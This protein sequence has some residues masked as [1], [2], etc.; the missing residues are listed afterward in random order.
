M[1]D[2]EQGKCE[3]CQEIKPI[4]RTYLYPSKYERNPNDI[5]GNKKKHNE[6]AYFIIIS[7]C[8]DCGVPKLTKQTNRGTA[9]P[10][11]K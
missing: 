2:I 7:T 6:G 3:F 1:G 5:S 11:T 10:T 4:Q 9:E 8:N